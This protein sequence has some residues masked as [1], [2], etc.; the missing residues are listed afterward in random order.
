MISLRTLEAFRS[1]MT[2]GSMS[3][4]ARV[5]GTSQPNVT[6]LIRQLE[7][8]VGFPVLRRHNRGVVPT[9]EGSA[10][11]AEVERAFR[12]LADINRVARDIER[13]RGGQISI[14]SIVGPM[15]RVMPLLAQRW[16]EQHDEINLTLEFH[17]QA[18]VIDQVRAGRFDLGIASPVDR[19]AGVDFLMRRKVR[20]V[21]IAAAGTAPPEGGVLDLSTIEGNLIVPGAAFVAAL[22]EHREVASAILNRTRMDVYYSLAA[23]ELAV[24]GLGVALVDS[25]TAMHHFNRDNAAVWPVKGAPHYDI[26]VFAPQRD[27]RSRIGAAYAEVLVSGLNEIAD[28]SEALASLGS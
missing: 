8:E 14:A 24:L 7:Q 28:A 1:V 16:Q 9:A 5:L 12:G 22:C 20:Y 21:A 2:A 23:G 25:L 15:V 11:Y 27:S 3:G 17:D 18:S 6:R 4:A 10:L 13:F 26:A 19:I